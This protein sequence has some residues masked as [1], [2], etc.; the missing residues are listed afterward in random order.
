MKYL[1]DFYTFFV[2]KYH[3]KQQICNRCCIYN[4]LIKYM[5]HIHNNIFNTL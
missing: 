4:A 3:Q 2:Q 1:L 5:L